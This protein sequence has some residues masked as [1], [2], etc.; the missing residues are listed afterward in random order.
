VQPNAML[1]LLFNQYSTGPI[2]GDEPGAPMLG[3][4]IF[5]GQGPW[6]VQLEIVLSLTKHLPALT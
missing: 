5:L 1:M 6:I 2:G 4:S 3:Y